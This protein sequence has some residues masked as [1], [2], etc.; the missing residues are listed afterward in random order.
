M[1]LLEEPLVVTHPASCQV[2]TKTGGVV[3]LSTQHAPGAGGHTGHRAHHAG[4]GVKDPGR[5]FRNSAKILIIF[6][7]TMLLF[8]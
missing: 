1:T 3:R 7:Q 4:G 6:T 2:R 5:L 8:L